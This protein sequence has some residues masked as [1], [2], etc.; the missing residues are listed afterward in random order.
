MRYIQIHELTAVVLFRCVLQANIQN[1]IKIVHSGSYIFF[2]TCF[3][4]QTLWMFYF[5]HLHAAMSSN[6]C[7]QHFH[8]TDMLS[9][10][11]MQSAKC[12]RFGATTKISTTDF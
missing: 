8:K 6:N 7:T 3:Y 10:L 12:V 5:L 4:V 2:V 1:M 11:K 9:A